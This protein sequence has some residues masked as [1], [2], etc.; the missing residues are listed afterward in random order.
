MNVE[1]K[2]HFNIAVLFLKKDLAAEI[3]TELI[4]TG[5]AA[6][7]CHN[8]NETYNLVKTKPPHIIVFHPEALGASM[9]EFIQTILNLNNEIQFVAV[10]PSVHTKLVSEYRPFNLKAIVPEGDHLSLRIAW[11]VDQMTEGLYGV[12]QN[13]KLHQDLHDQRQHPDPKAHQTNADPKKGSDPKAVDAYQWFSK[14]KSHFEDCAE[15]DPLVSNYLTLINQPIVFLKVLPTLQSIVLTNGL[16]ADWEKYKDKNLRLS[17]EEMDLIKNSHDQNSAPIWLKVW[18]DE[19][20]AEKSYAI[21]SIFINDTLIGLFLSWGKSALTAEQIDIL[22]SMF[23]VYFDKVHS[24]QM[25]EGRE[26]LDPT[27]NMYNRKAYYLRLEEE[28]ARADRTSQPLSL[29]KLGLDNREKVLKAIGKKNLEIIVK[30]ISQLLK[31]SSRLNDSAART[32]DAEFTLIL[33]DSN[34]DGALVRAER[35]RQV[36]EGHPFVEGLKITVSCGI[37]EYPKLAKNF[38]DL[39]ITCDKAL[40]IAVENGGNKVCLYSKDQRKVQLEVD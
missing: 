34:K 3:R 17:K 32:N 25:H 8:E 35:L 28:V 14:V 13:E 33:S 39:D 1:M 24:Q 21:R 5:Y 4:G 11:S 40:R 9:N 29:L 36:V 27:T 10:M 26:L 12:Y 18:M 19:T 20:F 2:S 15:R 16:N 6:N 38:S 30:N 31:K 37:S 7:V 22:D 23:S